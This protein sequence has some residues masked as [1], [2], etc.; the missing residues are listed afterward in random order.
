[1][2]E[3]KQRST[4]LDDIT[5]GVSFDRCA[6]PLGGLDGEPLPVIGD[7]GYYADICAAPF[8]LEPPT[9]TTDHSPAFSAISALAFDGDAGIARAD[10]LVIEN[11][12]ATIAAPLTAHP[13]LCE[14]FYKKIKRKA[15][16]D[17]A[18]NG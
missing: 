14:F 12:A 13:E 17:G 18:S 1:M 4:R 7:N 2:E 9:V 15:E 3:N 16:K 8:E 10:A 6:V 5:D 11:D